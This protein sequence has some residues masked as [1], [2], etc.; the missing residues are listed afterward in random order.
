MPK[1]GTPLW[2]SRRWGPLCTK[3]HKVPIFDPEHPDVQ[4]MIGRFGT[5]YLAAI[6]FEEL[7]HCQYILQ[8]VTDVDIQHDDMGAKSEDEESGQK[9]RRFD[10]APEGTPLWEFWQK[11]VEQERGQQ[12]HQDQANGWEAYDPAQ[13]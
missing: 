8:G 13:H 10:L 1:N 6:I 2:E 3:V 11:A 4:K 5:A 9:T 12:R 7:L